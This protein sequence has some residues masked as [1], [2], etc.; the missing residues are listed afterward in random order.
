VGIVIRRQDVLRTLGAANELAK[1]HGDELEARADLASWSERILI[2][3]DDKCPKTYLAVLSVLLA[4]RTMHG[5]D[6]LNVLDIKAKSSDLG[7]SASSVAGLV[8]G[9]AKEQRIDLRATSTQPMNNQPFT[10][11]AHITQDMQVQAKFESQWDAF[12]GMATIVN[13]MS[14]AEA[15]D[16]L[17]LL[18][19]QCRKTDAPTIQ[20]QLRVQGITSLDRVQA[21]V[22]GFVNQFSDNGKVGQAFVAALYDL[23]YSADQVVLGATQDPDAITPGDVQVGS[24][25]TKAWLWVEAKQKAIVTGDITSFFSKVH[26]AGG[27]RVA[28][29]AL[30]NHG[31]SGN[32]QIRTIKREA[33]RL[34]IGFEVIDSPWDALNWLLPLAPGRYEDVAARLLER[35]HARLVQSGASALC[36]AALTELASDLADVT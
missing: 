36:L 34:G 15:A 16:T 35:L 4:A 30:V 9:F 8:A 23:V 24:G 20:V 33:R 5:P 6:V 3:Q 14:S 22:A 27:E 29:F 18:F 26:A 17:A 31:Y 13:E 11:K 21:A 32:L 1:F 25:D 28:Y 19:H 10:F 2:L 12:Y 7:Y